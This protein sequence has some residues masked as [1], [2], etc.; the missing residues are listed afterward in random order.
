MVSRFIEQQQVGAADQRLRQV[1]AHT[2]A[3]GEVADRAGKLLVAEAEAVQQ[4]GGARADGPRVNRVQLTVNGGNSVAV[5]T[6]VGVI[7]LSFQLAEFAVTV[8]DILQSGLRQ[9]RV[10]WFTHAS[11][12]LLG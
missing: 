6:F 3:A 11:C 1:E 7:Q 4:A 10:S 5:I 8:N 9:R 12:Q 2:P